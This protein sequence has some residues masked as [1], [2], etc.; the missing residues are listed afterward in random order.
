LTL[1]LVGLV[2]GAT[3]FVVS[4][5]P[6]EDAIAPEAGEK[7]QVARRLIAQKHW[8][9]G[10]W[11]LSKGVTETLEGTVI[12]HT[13]GITI[14]S[15]EGKN[16]NVLTPA[17]WLVDGN[18]VPAKDLIPRLSGSVKMETLKVVYSGN[19]KTT[20][21]AVYKITAE[22]LIAEAVLPVNIQP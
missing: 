21:Y 7:A 12:A 19:V 22:N 16:I 3:T 20:I 15:V 2:I 11:L 9:L 17:K 8:F 14:L 1:L 18:I 10:R 6:S 5:V 13:P 4:A